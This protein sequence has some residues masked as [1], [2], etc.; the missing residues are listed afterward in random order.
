M[1][2]SIRTRKKLPSSFAST[3]SRAASTSSSVTGGSAVMS[4]IALPYSWMK[5]G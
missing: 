3:A 2:R 4:Q 5:Y 1:V